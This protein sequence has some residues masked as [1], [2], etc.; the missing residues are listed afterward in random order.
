MPSRR[1]MSCFPVR[2]AQRLVKSAAICAASMRLRPLTSAPARTLEKRSPVPWNCPGAS[3]AEAKSVHPVSRSKQAAPT[4]PGSRDT[5]VSTTDRRPSRLR[6][7]AHLR[8]SASVFR[9]MLSQSSPSR[10]AASVRLGVMTSARAASSPMAAHI[11][12]V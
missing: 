3:G 9:E 11:S 12:G 5:P 4:R 7:S 8:Q 2:A 10:R 1:G 6:A